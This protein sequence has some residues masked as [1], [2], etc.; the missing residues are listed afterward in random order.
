MT[1]SMTIARRHFRASL[2]L[3]VVGAAVVSAG[4]PAWADEP[5]LVVEG[6]GWGHGVGMSQEGALT[7]GA[8]GASTDEI[9]AQFYPG[10]TKGSAEATVRVVVLESTVRSETL[11]FPGGGEIRATPSGSQPPGFPVVVAPGGSVEVLHEGD[12][13]RVARI[14]E[15]AAGRSGEA[16]VF[17]LISAD[18][19]GPS[20]A[21]TL[22]SP[23]T[24][25]TSTSTPAVTP[26]STPRSTS[27]STSSSTSTSTST[28]T[29]PRASIS[30]APGAGRG[31]TAPTLWAVPRAG[32]TTS[33]ASRARRYR[34]ALEVGS[35]ADGG[36]R[37]VNHVPVESY[38]RGM[39]EVVDPGWPAAALRA[40][41]IAARTY[42][43]R[44]A[45]AGTELCDDDRCQVYLGQTA[46]YAAMDAAVADSQGQV[47]LFGGALASTFY[48]ANAGGVSATADEGFG[49]GGGT[50]PY[51]VSAPYPSTDPY[52]WTE[53]VSLADIGRRFAYPGRPT[54]ARVVA[55]GPSGRAT[56]VT[57]DGD[58]GPLSVD[59]PTFAARLGLKSTLF[60][61]RTELGEAPPLADPPPAA[62]VVRGIGDALPS[63]G[64]IG[65]A[66]AVAPA[67]APRSPLGRYVPGLLLLLVADAAVMLDRYRRRAAPG[68]RDV[69]LVFTAAMRSRLQRRS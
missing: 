1:V 56:V 51:L 67:R 26:L 37:L 36:L 9:L 5:V 44:S 63:L 52:P 29:V 18:V 69:R 53:R 49:P 54:G 12:L 19:A 60:V 57:I 20:S 17:R 25:S 11:G 39:G 13:Y 55:A 8:A 59:G 66:V 47:L 27:T 40:Q 48:S 61:L 22:P 50:Y 28:S 58:G 41:A 23:S 4:R 2:A 45:A 6:R 43:L 10:T 31:T 15:K 34:G 7:M 38:L 30:T 62:L 14:T 33:V 42:A 3:L 68:G 32:A 21:V 64:P 16:G 24:T 65:R 46:E 35:G